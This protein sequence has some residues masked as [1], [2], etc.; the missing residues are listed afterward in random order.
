M[1]ASQAV[2]VSGQTDKLHL[3]SG[4]AKKVIYEINQPA[5]SVPVLN[6]LKDEASWPR[7]EVPKLNVCAL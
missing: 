4:C 2:Q 6:N 5:T 1:A 3:Q 7:E